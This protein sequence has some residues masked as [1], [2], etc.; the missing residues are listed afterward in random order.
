M[1]RSC[2]VMTIIAASQALHCEGSRGSSCTHEIRHVIIIQ[3]SFCA[4]VSNKSSVSSATC[5]QASELC[6]CG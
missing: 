5:E 4:L 1:V 3:F 6:S 2:A